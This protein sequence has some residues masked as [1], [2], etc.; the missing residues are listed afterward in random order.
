MRRSEWRA[1][2]REAPPA[3]GFFAIRANVEQ[4]FNT[5]DQSP[6]HEKDLDD[7]AAEFILSWAQA[8]HRPDPVDL[9]VHLDELPDGSFRGAVVVVAD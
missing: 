6:V 8:F 5:M 1:S 3:R 4:L 9:I 7:D 2:N